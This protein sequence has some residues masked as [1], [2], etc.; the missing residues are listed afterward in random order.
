MSKVLDLIEFRTERPPY[1]FD[2]E[3]S[4]VRWKMKRT[5]IDLDASLEAAIKARYEQA[6]KPPPK[7]P[8]HARVTPWKGLEQWIGR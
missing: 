1:R 7:E 4:L 3:D 5:N 6:G 2:A 8:K